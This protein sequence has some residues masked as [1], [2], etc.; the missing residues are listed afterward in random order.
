MG[1]ILTDISKSFGKEQVFSS[2]SAELKDGQF[3]CL[4]GSSG[5]GKTTLLSLLMGLKKQDAGSIQ[6]LDG[7]KISAVFQEDRLVESFTAL[8]NVKIVLSPHSPYDDES[9]LSLFSR[10]GITEADQKPVSEYSGGMKRRV[11]ILRALLTDFDLLIM[12]EPLKGFDAETKQK[13]IEFIK[14]KSHGKTVLMTSHDPSDAEAFSAHI[15][16]IE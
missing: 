15:L 5:S 13:V 8:K 7:K 14:E 2:F 9:I 6:G 16:E 4:M 11:A 3:Y 1:I 10:I 12:D